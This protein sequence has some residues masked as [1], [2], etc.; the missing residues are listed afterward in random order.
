[1][2]EVMNCKN[3]LQIKRSENDL[4]YSEKYQFQEQRNRLCD[5]I[6]KFCNGIDEY[7]ATLMKKKTCYS[8][9]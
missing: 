4:P 9:I 2:F 7:S 1:M 5:R 8:F 6:N 3:S